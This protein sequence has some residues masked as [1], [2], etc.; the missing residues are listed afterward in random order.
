MPKMLTRIDSD[1]HYAVKP[2]PGLA[3]KISGIF[4]GREQSFDS[5]MDSSDDEDEVEAII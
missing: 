2:E 4:A 1:S 3:D 5:I